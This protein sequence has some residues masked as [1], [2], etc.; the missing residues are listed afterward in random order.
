MSKSS[1]KYQ[2]FEREAQILNHAKETL[3]IPEDD[4]NTKAFRAEYELLTQSYAQL[5]GEVKLLTSVS[6][7]LQNKLNKANE[8]I[9]RKNEEL[10]Q[11]IE[12]LTKARAGRR[13]TTIVLL[14]AVL[15][16]VISEWVIDPQIQEHT[17]LFGTSGVVMLKV[18]AAVA[19]KPLETLLEN[20]ML[21][22]SIKKT[23]QASRK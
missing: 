6:D 15:F 5:L 14:I 3:Q 7:R 12:M 2:V 9:A 22:S 16:F 18:L 17:L 4:M 10:T 8:S 1:E 11:T 23:N 13:A 21:K 19:L 20:M